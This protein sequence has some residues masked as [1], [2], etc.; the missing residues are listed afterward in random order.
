MKTILLD[1]VGSTNDAVRRYLPARENTIVC[2]RRQT[3]GRGTKS[4]SFLSEEGGVYLSA[5]IF[6]SDMP[7]P[8]AFRVMAHAAVAVC[9]TASAFGA[10]PEIKWPND[11]LAQGRKLCGILIENG[12]AAGKVDHSVVG[13]GLNVCNSLH[14]IENAITL[15]EAASRAL[16]VETVRDALIANF[17]QSSTFGD[18]LSFVHFLGRDVEVIEGEARYRAVARRIAEDGRLEV[19]CGGELRLLSAAEISLRI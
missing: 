16:S 10:E 6:P 2:A 19:E 11:V 12:V 15:S 8:E 14:G 5:L 1:A 3:A 17:R 18:Y 4:R 13:I 7:A 9:R